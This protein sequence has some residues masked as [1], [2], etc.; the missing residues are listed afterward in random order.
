MNT[1]RTACQSIPTY[2]CE[3]HVPRVNGP[4]SFVTGPTIECPFCVAS[5]L[6]DAVGAMG[7]ILGIIALERRLWN[8]DARGPEAGACRGQ[9][10]VPKTVTEEWRCWM[11]GVVE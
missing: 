9:N 5:R 3:K 11:C 2:E 10:F 1:D 7:V 4:I 8:C 6:G